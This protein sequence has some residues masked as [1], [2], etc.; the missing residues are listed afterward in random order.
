MALSGCA[1]LGAISS[2]NS[3]DA[4]LLLPACPPDQVTLEFGWL[5]PRPAT[6]A[7]GRVLQ[8]FGMTSDDRLSFELWTDRWR[9]CAF[10]RGIV[11]EEANR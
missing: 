9:R 4:K 3:R 2:G 10:E 1:S 11:I 5:G 6:A 7:D 8:I